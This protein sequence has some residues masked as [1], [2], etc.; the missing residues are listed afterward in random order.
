MFQHNAESKIIL[1]VTP[2]D[3]SY[4]PRVIHQTEELTLN[5]SGRIILN[6]Q[7]EHNISISNEQLER[8]LLELSFSLEDQKRIYD[9][10]LIANSSDADEFG[11]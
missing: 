4:I 2:L 7:N 10:T 6:V 9:E 11:F 8:K 5:D 1:S 3:S